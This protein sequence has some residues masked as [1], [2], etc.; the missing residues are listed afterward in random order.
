MVKQLLNMR[1]FFIVMCV[2]FGG[3][4]VAMAYD[5]E[6]EGI[7]YNVV[8]AEEKT[9]AVTFKTS[10]GGDY[11]GDVVIPATAVYNEEEY[12]V[13]GILQKAFMKCSGL[14]SVEISE[15][16]NSVGT[17]AFQGCIALTE[18]VYPKELLPCQ[19]EFLMVVLLY[20]Q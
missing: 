19:M 3:I 13:T 7:Y 1:R 8:S 9:C 20:Y 18:I 4:N 11:S 12:T 10:T 5:F 15:T 2:L 6:V 17:S 16:V 14:T